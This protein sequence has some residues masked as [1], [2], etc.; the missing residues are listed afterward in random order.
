LAIEGVLM[1]R[2]VV[3]MLAWFTLATT[4]HAQGSQR[5]AL[6]VGNEAYSGALTKLNRPHEDAEKISGALQTTGFAVTQRKDQGRSEILR[7]VRALADRLK[8]AGPEAV[9]FFYYS[10]HG[11]S[12]LVGDRRRNYMIPVGTAIETPDDLVAEGIPLDDIIAI[13]QRSKAKA[14]FIVF[15][16]CRSE[17]PWSK[18][19]ADPDKAFNAVS[20]G[21]GM[22]IA[23]STAEGTSA[24]DDG[25]FAAALASQLVEPGRTH[26]AAFDAASRS[27][28]RTRGVDRRPWYSNQIDDEIYFAARP[29][30]LDQPNATPGPFPIGTVSALLDRSPAAFAAAKSGRPVAERTFRDRLRDGTEGPELVALPTGSFTMGSPA[31]EAGRSTDEGPTR[32]VTIGSQIAVTRYEITLAEFRRFLEATGRTMSGNCYAFLESEGRQWAQKVDA[33]WLKPGFIQTG[34]QPVVCVSWDDAKAY[35][36]WL[37][38]QTGESYRLLSEAEWEYAA[39]SGQQAPYSFGADAASGCR[40]MNGAD[41]TG[42]RKYPAWTNTNSCDDEYLNTAPVGVFAP[43]AF[44]L[45]DLNGNVWEWVEDCYEDSY[46]AGQPS[47]G[48]AFIKVSCSIRVYRG[49]SWN[50]IPDV[51]RSANRDRASPSV[52]S[53]SLGFRLARTP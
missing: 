18:G 32:T 40:Y 13:L 44:G 23:Y 35:A 16:A 48:R 24:P 38:Q 20:A 45:F 25:A 46:A 52:R 53:G 3:A 14:I 31:S 36:T 42:K 43:N 10:G 28:G 9:G 21:P 47:D 49:G 39:R 7:E 11:A 2:F 15:D 6:A 30:L 5:L 34:A 50:D 27:V 12:A 4:A 29:P 41:A 8:A 17:L 26:L 22:F 33:N 1:L 37:S 51:L 19:G